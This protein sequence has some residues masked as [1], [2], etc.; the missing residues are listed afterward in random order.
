MDFPHQSAKQKDSKYT[1]KK[2]TGIKITIIAK[3]LLLVGDKS[4]TKPCT[5]NT[6]AQKRLLLNEFN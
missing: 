2:T 4:D 3:E 1:K 5:L 6:H